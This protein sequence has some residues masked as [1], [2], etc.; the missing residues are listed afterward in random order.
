MENQMWPKLA[1]LS[2]LASTYGAGAY[3]AGVYSSSLQIGPVTLPNTG[4]TWLALGT[5]ALLAVGGGLLVW[6]LQRRRQG[7][8]PPSA[9]PQ[10]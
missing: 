2:F 6:R 8:T 10:P 5:A 1:A 7:Q 3:G 9:K 4:T